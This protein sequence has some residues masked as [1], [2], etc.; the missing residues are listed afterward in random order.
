MYVDQLVFGHGRCCAERRGLIVHRHRLAGAPQLGET[1]L[2][3]LPEETTVDPYPQA[4]IDVTG[5][6]PDAAHT[7]II[8]HAQAMIS[9]PS[10][11]VAAAYPTGITAAADDAFRGL[12]AILERH[13]PRRCTSCGSAPHV[14]AVHYVDNA[15]GRHYWPSD[16][17]RDAARGLATGIPGQ[18]EIAGP[19][20]PG[21]EG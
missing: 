11:E 7:R 4:R 1:L 19:E 13:R 14:P 21:Q 8:E 6:A 2:D 16:D 10:G 17:Y 3:Q 9:D 20:N 15:T 5:L 18:A 12:I